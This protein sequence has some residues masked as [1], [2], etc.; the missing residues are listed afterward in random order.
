LVNASNY[1]GIIDDKT[2]EGNRLSHLKDWVY[3]LSP[4]KQTEGL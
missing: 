1:F 2:I 4:T 3:A